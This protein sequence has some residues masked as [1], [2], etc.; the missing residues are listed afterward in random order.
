MCSAER[1][2]PRWR[3]FYEDLFDIEKRPGAGVTLWTNAVERQLE[4]VRGANYRHRLHFS[5][6][7]DEKRED[8]SAEYELHADVYFLA[9]AIRRLLLFHDAM[10]RQIKDPRLDAAKRTFTAA[11]PEAK[12]FRDFYE[13]LDAYL[14]DDPKKH[15]KKIPGRAA[16]VLLSRWDSDNVTVAFGPLRMDVTLA[17]VAMVE[18]GKASEAV[19]NEH[20]ERIKA[21]RPTERP[22]A[23][24]GIP[25]MLEITMGVSAII[26]GE[27]EPASGPRRHPARNPYARGDSPGDH[28]DGSQAAVVGEYRSVS[29][30]VPRR[31]ALSSV[32][33]DDAASRAGAQRTPACR[34]GSR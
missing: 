12:L 20:L 29:K 10:A 7:E 3:R 2:V 4:R 32:P 22:P 23:E 21:E 1:M 18:L 16:P 30:T 14:L 15:V 34:P 8:S 6:K 5:P 25:R 11:A 13:H 28:G 24:D 19:W 31:G 9:L 27:D 33:V 17:A 26:G